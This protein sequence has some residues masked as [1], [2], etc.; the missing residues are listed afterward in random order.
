MA[1]EYFLASISQRLCLDD[2]EVSVSVG[3][4]QTLIAHL[5][6]LFVSNGRYQA[7]NQI[8]SEEQRGLRTVVST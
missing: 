6:A 5:R 3:C 4:L 7:T 2:S 1:F 8:C